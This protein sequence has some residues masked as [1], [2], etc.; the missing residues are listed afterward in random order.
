MV[1]ASGAQADPRGRDADGD[2][3]RRGQD[4]IGTVAS[5]FENTGLA[6]R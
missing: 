3:G 2:S 6:V 5:G 1:A 4:L